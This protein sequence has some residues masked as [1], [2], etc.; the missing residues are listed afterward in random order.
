MKA[1]AHHSKYLLIVVGT[2][3]GAQIP[4]ANPI[5]GTLGNLHFPLWTFVGLL[6]RS[7]LFLKSIQL[8]PGSIGFSCEGTESDGQ[9][10]MTNKT[11][12]IKS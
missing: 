12:S 3:R 6:G 10:L 9:Q 2:G 8:G 4:D 11:R 5:G 7:V 1:I